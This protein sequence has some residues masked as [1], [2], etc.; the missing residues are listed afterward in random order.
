MV[1]ANN[2]GTN[3]KHSVYIYMMLALLAIILSACGSDDTNNTTV[4][5]N[6][7]EMKWD[8]GQWKETRI[9]YYK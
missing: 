3:E 1:E 2:R 7:D 5:S 8:Q 6:W 4:S 9:S